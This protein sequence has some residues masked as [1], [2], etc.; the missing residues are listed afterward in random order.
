[1]WDPS[2]RY[3]QRCKKWRVKI[4]ITSRAGNRVNITA[5]EQKPRSMDEYF[6]VTVLP[7]DLLSAANDHDDGDNERS[8]DT[9]KL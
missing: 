2:Q 4:Q 3:Q 6:A 9:I 1:L 8:Q 7:N 5:A